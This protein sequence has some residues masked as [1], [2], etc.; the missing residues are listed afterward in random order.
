MPAFRICESAYRDL[1]LVYE[2]NGGRTDTL[3]TTRVNHG[4]GPEP[5]QVHSGSV[6]IRG[7]GWALVVDEEGG[8]EGG[9]NLLESERRLG[10][11]ETI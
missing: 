7:R 3:L 5:A 11:G 10:K 4:N 2:G 9:R 8:S 6:I 1:M